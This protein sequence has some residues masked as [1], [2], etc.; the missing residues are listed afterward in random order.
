MAR[1]RFIDTE[2]QVSKWWLYQ[3]QLGVRVHFEN[4]CMSPGLFGLQAPVC[5]LDVFRDPVLVAANHFQEHY[6]T[7][8]R[9]CPERG[10]LQGSSGCTPGLGNFLHRRR[11]C[12]TTFSIVHALLGVRGEIHRPKVWEHYE[13]S[14]RRTPP[15]RDVATFA[16]HGYKELTPVTPTYTHGYIPII[17]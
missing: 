17:S 4:G 6:L 13:R 9:T 15:E 11:Q 10:P 7:A 5:R 16:Q 1:T 2:S 3:P 12:L 8:S 14:L